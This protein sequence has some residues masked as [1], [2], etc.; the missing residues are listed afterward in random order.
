MCHLILM[1]PVLSLPILWLVPMSTAA[2]IYGVILA[3]SLLMYFYVMRAMRRAVGTGAEGIRQEI[4]RVIEVDG[5]RLRVRVHS[6]E[7]SAVSKDKLSEG[8]SVRIESVDGLLLR[9][10]RLDN[11]ALPPG[12]RPALRAFR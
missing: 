4:G 6:E 10:R 8:D 12:A 9:V 5:K 1:L 11:D 2:P 3:L 7:W